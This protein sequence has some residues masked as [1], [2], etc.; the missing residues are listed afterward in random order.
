MRPRGGMGPAKTVELTEDGLWAGYAQTSQI[1]RGGSS[2]E[3]IANSDSERRTV[4]AA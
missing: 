4:S 2:A 3:Q 1:E